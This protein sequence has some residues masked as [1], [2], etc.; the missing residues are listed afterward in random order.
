MQVYIRFFRY[1]AS[2]RL[3]LLL[4]ML[5]LMITTLANLAVPR[6]LQ[7]FLDSIS[8]PVNENAY[9]FLNFLV[10]GFVVLYLI[11][12]IFYYGQEYLLAFVGQKVVMRIREELYRKLQYLSLGYHQRMR[13]GELISRV[14]NDIQSVENSVVLALPGLISQPLTVFGSIIMV[15]VIHWRLAIFTMA[16]IPFVAFAINHFGV[17]LRQTSGRIQS[18]LSDITTLIQEN[19]SAIRIVKAFSREESEIQRFRDALQTNFQASLKAVQLMATMTPVIEILGSIGGIAFFWYGGREVIRGALTTGE[20]IGFIGYMGIMITPLKLISRD[21]GLM[22]KAGASL[23]RIFEVL[24]VQECIVEEENAVD[25]PN[26][27]GTVAFQQVSMSY[28]QENKEVLKEIS[29]EVQPGQVVAFVGESG[30]GKT[31]LVNLLPRFYDPTEGRVTIDG[32]DLRDVTI[33][34]LRKQ[35]AIVP[36]DT[37]LFKGTIA[38]NIAYGKP[39]ATMDEIEQAA[40]RANAHKF[41]SEFAKGYE[42]MVGERGQSLSGGQRQRIAIARAILANPRILI[43]DEATSALDTASEILVQEALEEV[44]RDRTTFVIAHRLSTIVNADRIVVMEQGQIV[45]IGT[46]AELLEQNG[47]YSKLYKTQM[48]RE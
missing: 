26:V 10:L 16:V 1:F 28:D 48:E 39:D 29:L 41:I 38:Y 44:M 3:K 6:I 18:S 45:E 47:Y 25:L 32:Y 17:R 9:A 13:V 40:R 2:L 34:S 23:E 31:T 30:A 43:L 12:G 27:K 19:F 36:Q 14:T 5:S 15:F 7:V 37:I 20:L 42:T 46:H 22:Q 8:N 11:K 24:D 33:R 21:L 4:G 35:I